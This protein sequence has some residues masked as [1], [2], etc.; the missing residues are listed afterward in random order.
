MNSEE[1]EQRLEGILNL[2]SKD[3]QE[4]LLISCNDAIGPTGYGPNEHFGQGT[5]TKYKELG[6]SDEDE[7][8]IT[9]LIEYEQK[10]RKDV[11]WASQVINMGEIPNEEGW[12]T[13]YAT[14]EDVTRAKEILGEK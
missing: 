14:E 2:L 6:L 10:V 3:L 7:A 12:G 13:R 1:N 9:E 8:F 5:E 4:V 11:F